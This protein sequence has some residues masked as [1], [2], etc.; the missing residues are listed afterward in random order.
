M[1]EQECFDVNRV[2]NGPNWFILKPDF[3][4]LE[5]T[6][7]VTKV[8]HT[9]SR[10]C[11]VCKC[12][13]DYGPSNHLNC[14]AHEV[15]VRCK[16]CG[17][18]FKLEL[19]RYSGTSKSLIN[20]ALADGKE[21][22]CFCSREC[23]N[24]NLCLLDKERKES[25]TGWY[26]EESIK[27]RNSSDAQTLRNINAVKSE[28]NGLLKVLQRESTDP[29][30][31]R[32]MYEARVRNGLLAKEMKMQSGQ[33]SRCREFS[34]RRNPFGL[35]LKCSNEVSFVKQF[36][37]E[38]ETL[39]YYDSSENK[40]V[41]WSDYKK[42]FCVNKTDLPEGF[43]L[44]PTFRDQNSQDWSNVRQAFEQNLVEN[45]IGWFVYIK[46]Y[47]DHD[48]QY[49]PLVVGKSGSKLVNVNGSDISFSTYINDGP[50]RRFLHE[51]GLEWCKTQIA[52]RPCSNECEA[53]Q[54]E[55]Q[56]RISNNLFGS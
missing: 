34:D 35:C 15:Y 46:F 31:A 30:F 2:I 6:R 20:N 16:I 28:T 33:C 27:A 45:N 51:E 56:I 14:R 53:L 36:I 24:K 7:S 38:N 23:Q 26:S 5:K 9:K 55:S 19:D 44:F 17:K 54:I 48:K 22:L 29:E 42:R 40:Y 21:L 37:I 8:K 4:K 13:F 11:Y 50:A 47:M 1:L 12:E 41:P 32:I 52:I 49:V 3:D 39:L 43:I 10:R 18:W 25:H